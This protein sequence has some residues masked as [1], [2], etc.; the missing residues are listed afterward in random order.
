[1]E[2]IKA[3]INSDVGE[4]ILHA[5]PGA[6][7]GLLGFWPVVV[8]WL[9]FFGREIIQHR[10]DIKR[11]YTVPQVIMEAHAPLVAGLIVMAF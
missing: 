2:R 3:F 8:V 11:V 9:C 10:D 7:A 1:M 4:I 5:I 6:L